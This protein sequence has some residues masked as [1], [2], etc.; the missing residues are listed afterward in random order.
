MGGTWTSRVHDMFQGWE[1][2]MPELRRLGGRRGLHGGTERK[3]YSRSP[4]LSTLGGGMPR[5]WR[6]SRQ[7]KGQVSGSQ[8]VGVDMQ[9]VCLE[10]HV[11]LAA[12]R[13]HKIASFRVER[14]LGA[15]SVREEG[16]K[17]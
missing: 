17:Q 4:G 15:D 3:D 14:K 16:A 13:S 9:T 7:D 11:F 2:G 10:D 12:D 8:G 5:D 6:G 1:Y